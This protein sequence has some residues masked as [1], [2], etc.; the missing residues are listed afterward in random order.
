[1]WHIMQKVWKVRQI[2]K[3]RRPYE[4]LYRKKFVHGLPWV[5]CWFE[6]TSFDPLY[7]I[8]SNGAEKKLQV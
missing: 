1:M 2:S 8:Y 4:F 3:A 6:K 7:Q 5:M